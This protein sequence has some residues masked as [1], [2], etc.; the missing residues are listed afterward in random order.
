VNVLIRSGVLTGVVPRVSTAWAV[1]E[2]VVGLKEDMV[3]A[4][5]ILVYS[6]DLV[7][8]EVCKFLGDCSAKVHALFVVHC[9]VVVVCLR[10]L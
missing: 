7:G 3:A 6:T 1:G 10:F 9:A 8:R 5:T 4:I 2:C